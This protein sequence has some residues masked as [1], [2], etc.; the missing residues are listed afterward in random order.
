MT[1]GGCTK[2]V[3]V[4]LGLSGIQEEEELPPK[5]GMRIT[6][7]ICKTC[8]IDLFFCT[9]DN[10]EVLFGIIHLVFKKSLCYTVLIRSK[11]L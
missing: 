3:A 1:R 6:S 11:E 4:E 9:T 5:S 2:G 7:H 8:V 10:N